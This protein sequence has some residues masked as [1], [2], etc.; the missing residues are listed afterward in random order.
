MPLI[1]K[2]APKGI[3]IA[4]ARL[5]L[6]L[7]NGLTW[8]NTPN[9]Y[10]SYERAYKNETNDNKLPEVFLGSANTGGVDYAEVFTDDTVSASSFFLVSD[11]RTIDDIISADVDI[12]FQVDLK[13]LYPN[14]AHRADEEAHEEVTT[15]LQNN[16]GNY[17]MTNMITGVANVYSDLRIT[18]VNLDDTQPYH[19]FKVTLN[20]TYELNGCN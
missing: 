17:P 8:K 11:N 2:I 19:I 6:S 14:I 5:Q 10:I 16:S 4:I 9:T 20:V 12:I 1:Q 13:K 3:D 15:V 7:Y 18:Q